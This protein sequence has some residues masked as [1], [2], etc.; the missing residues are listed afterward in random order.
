M[1]I[2]NKQQ[3]IDWCIQ[4]H[5]NTNHFYDTYLPYKFHLN[6][7]AQV[8][9]DFKDLITNTHFVSG[10]DILDKLEICCFGHDLIEDT[11]TSYNDV[12]KNLGKFEADIIY[13]LTNEK[14]RNRKE[15]ANESYYKGI[16]ETDFAV[17]VKMCDRIANV[18]YSK[19][20]KSDQFE[21]YKKENLHFTSALGFRDEC[22]EFSG[23]PYFKMYVYL[24]KLFNDVA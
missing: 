2:R 19:M 7:V 4:Q 3:K 21:M 18:Q 6:M 10:E 15:R 14:G 1:S 24:N 16:R 11:R 12:V 8:C 22:E 5:E 9:K 23:H 13:A 17:F 20:T